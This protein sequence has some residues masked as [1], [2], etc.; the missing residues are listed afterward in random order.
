M[1]ALAALVAATSSAVQAAADTPASK[2]ARMA[3][4]HSS[5]PSFLPRVASSSAAAAAVESGEK[6][7]WV[8]APVVILGRWQWAGCLWRPQ[9]AHLG[10]S[11]TLCTSPSTCLSSHGLSHLC[12]G[13]SGVVDER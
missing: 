7:L 3:A 4:R 5:R 9:L 6:A 8:E 11:S 10:S 13:S 2:A 12:A 1:F